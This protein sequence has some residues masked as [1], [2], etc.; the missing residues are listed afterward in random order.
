MTRKSKLQ[1]NAGVLALFLAALAVD[2]LVLSQPGGVGLESVGAAELADGSAGSGGGSTAQVPGMDEEDAAPTL[3]QRLI[4]YDRVDPTRDPFRLS[5]AMRASLQPAPDEE[6]E[7]EQAPPE[8]DK[9]RAEE[10]E[11]VHRLE[12]VLVKGEA[13]LAVVNGLTVRLG[14]SVAGFSLV[15]VGERWATFERD[16]VRITLTLPLE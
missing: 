15:S 4:E 3:D 5:A 13:S 2:K 8:G 14:E 9:P 16:A 6:A 10:F 7:R 11:S 12:A 1:L